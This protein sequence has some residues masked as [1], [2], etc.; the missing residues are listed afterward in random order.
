MRPLNKLVKTILFAV[1]ITVSPALLGQSGKEV[2]DLNVQI[3]KG[4]VQKNIEFLKK[5]YG[6]D[7]VFTHG[8]GLVEGKESWLKAIQRPELEYLSR[9][10]DSTQVEMHGQVAIV[11]GRLVVERVAQDTAKYGLWYVRVFEKRK[12]QW[13]MISHRTTKEWHY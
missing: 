2:L 4:V 11:V 6:N 9:V 3:D 13:Q 7:F 12:N 5:V 8:T 1:S 10:H